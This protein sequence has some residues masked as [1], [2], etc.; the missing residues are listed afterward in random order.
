MEAADRLSSTGELCPE[1]SVDSLP[2]FDYDLKD[3]YILKGETIE[4]MNK[5]LLA[6]FL[7]ENNL[8]GMKGKP[9]YQTIT[10]RGCPYNCSY[11]CNNVYW[12]LLKGQQ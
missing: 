5:D 7:S 1:S 4:A 9:C 2:F 10:A 3:H 8:P 6:E 12:T 11:C